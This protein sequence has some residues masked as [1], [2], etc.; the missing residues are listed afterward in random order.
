MVFIF[1]FLLD[2]MNEANTQ[3]KKVTESFDN[4]EYLYCRKTPNNS[5]IVTQFSDE[6]F[7]FAE[8]E[9]YNELFIK[10]DNYIKAVKDSVSFKFIEI[11]ALSTYLEEHGYPEY[12]DK[13]Y[14]VN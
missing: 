5:H 3:I 12:K 7:E 13:N 10:V 6:N 1:E 11:S 2:Q 14:P 4:F 9:N 8:K